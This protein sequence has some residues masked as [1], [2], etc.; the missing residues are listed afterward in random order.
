MNLIENIKL[1]L[2]SLK[3]NKM[4]ALLTMLGII[5]GISSVIMITTMGSIMEKSVTDIFDSQ[6]GSNLVG[7]Q[8]SLKKDAARDYVM[9]GDFITEEMIKSVE[10]R[11]ADQIDVI[12]LNYGSEKAKTRFKREDLELVVY[13]VNPG[14][15]RQS[16]T[17][18]VAGRYI[19]DKDIS[20]RG[21]VCVISDKQAIK[22]YGDTKSALGQVL[23][24]K[25]LDTSYDF[26][27]VGVY[28]YKMNAMMSAM[29]NAMGEDW[30]NEIY[31]PYTTLARMY[32]TDEINFYWF[33]V[34]TQKGVDA[35]KFC[36]DVKAYMD[37]RF[38]RDNDSIEIYYQTAEAQLSMINQVLGVLS[39]V[40]SVIAG[41]SLLVGGIGVMNIMLVSVTERT[42]EIGIRKALGARNSA[43]RSQ[44]IIE[45][46]IICLIGGFIGIIFGVLLGNI[47][48]VIVGTTAPPSIGSIFLAVSFAMAIG[49]FFGYYP[50]NRASKLD[51]IEALRYE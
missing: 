42:R 40:I 12:A 50:A 34:N 48:G 39:T 33:N 23:T 25:M 13:G 5:I 20:K 24:V 16:M 22:L 7:F 45:S 28:E 10:E 26:T 6:G 3:S 46:V 32:G 37:N 9:D 1:A 49:V 18:V 51:P 35:T 31:I 11:F 47:A 41:I 44:F 27:V 14:Y 8:I 38:Y 36:S 43:I 21:N 17:E 29:V 2:T 4:R 15:I 19:S 30:N